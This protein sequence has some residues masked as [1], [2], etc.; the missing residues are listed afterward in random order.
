[1]AQHTCPSC[2]RK[3]PKP[4]AADVLA[5]PASM[6]RDQ[7]FAYY[8]KIA[9]SQDRMFFQKN[10]ENALYPPSLHLQAASAALPENP[11][12]AQIAAIRSAWRTERT[13]YELTHGIPSV[14]SQPFASAENA[15][16][17]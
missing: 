3:L 1:M 4:K 6:T 15:D 12:P 17:A 11:K 2:G 7:L 10:L 9:P 13:R 5:D 14:G 16:V 8:K